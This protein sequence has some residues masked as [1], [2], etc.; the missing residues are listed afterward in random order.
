MEISELGTFSLVGGTALSLQYGHRTS[1][2]IDLFCSDGYDYGAI[3]ESLKETFGND[4]QFEEKQSTWGI[5]CFIRNIKVDIINYYRHP[6][7]SPDIVADGIRM[8]ASNDIAAMK[9]Q[10]I[11][12]R[13]RKKD[14][15]DIAELL[16]EYTVKEIIDCYEK[17]YPSQHLLIS[18]PQALTYF[19][20]AEESE[21]PVSLKG[22]TWE[23]VKK[24]IAEKV[25][26]YL[27]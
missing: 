10:A 13:G 16:S 9:V 12:G 19:A 26:E 4:F 22:Q 25:N 18:I 2:D 27:K 17:K 3:V 21:D 6:K 15:W 7:I 1:I 5:F 11:L 24:S 23:S 8:Y 20:D 14:F